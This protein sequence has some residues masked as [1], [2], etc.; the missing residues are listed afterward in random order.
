MGDP[1]GL[2]DPVPPTT[3]PSDLYSSRDVEEMPGGEVHRPGPWPRPQDRTDLLPAIE[4][5]GPGAGLV[6]W[7]S[8]TPNKQG[9]AATGGGAFQVKTKMASDPKPPGMSDA[10]TIY[11]D[12]IRLCAN[13]AESYQKQ[14]DLPE[15]EKARDVR[16]GQGPCGEA[17]LSDL[18]TGKGKDCH[19]CNSQILGPAVAY[20]RSGDIVEGGRSSLEFKPGAESKLELNS[21]RWSEVPR[22]EGENFHHNRASSYS[23]RIASISWRA[24]EITSRIRRSFSGLT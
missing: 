9:L 2:G 15:G 16:E 6:W 1:D 18:K 20:I 22:V 10:V 13:L 23:P 17:D 19:S 24:R 8:S 14:G 7:F 3:P 4:K 21:L 5:V 11:E 12:C